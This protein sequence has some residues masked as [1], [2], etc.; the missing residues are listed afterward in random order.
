MI[1]LHDWIATLSMWWWPK[2]ADHL[3]QATLFGLVVL[4]AS[5]LL[6]R[7]PA[8]LRHSLWLLASIKF[9]IPAVA[10]VLLSRW[11]GLDSFWLWLTKP[12]T[13]TNGLWQ[14]IAAPAA[15]LLTNNYEL[16]VTATNGTHSEFYCALTG[17]WLAGCAVLIGIWWR[18]RTSYRSAMGDGEP[19]FSGREWLALERARKLLGLHRNV[20]LVLSTRPVEPGV[21][22]IWNPVIVL[23]E[24]IAKHLDDDELL[25]IMLHELVHIERRDNLIG[26]L[27]IALAGL[28]WFHPL[29]WFI[30]RKLFDERE[31]ACDER[32]LELYA[33]PETYAASILKVVRF[34]F[35]WN[36]AGVIG[37]GG[38]S[39]LRRRIE[40]IM[41]TGKGKRSVSIGAKILASIALGIALVAIV[42]G[43]TQSR[44]R[45]GQDA[46]DKPQP[47][48]VINPS[49]PEDVAPDPPS[50]VPQNPNSPAPP[51]SPSLPADLAQP[52]APPQRAD[53]AQPAAVVQPANPS[54][55]PTPRGADVIG[56]PAQPKNAAQPASPV[57][58]ATP[59]AEP[60]DVQ[61]PPQKPRA[62][63]DVKKG[64]L[65]SA[66]KPVYPAEAKEKKVEG[67]VAVEIVIGEEGTVVSA[68]PISGPDLLLGAA[69]DAAMQAR[70]EP[71]LV[72]GK[73]A[74]VTGTMSYK[75]ALKDK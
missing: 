1:A 35:G 66:P 75:F 22:K 47:Q 43:E 36:A 45:S 3:W 72:N 58:P 51:A 46:V 2:L 12:F 55:P 4:F 61:E 37:A 69:K 10:L 20:R 13:E 31:Q 52:P 56:V 15:V 30:S 9:V 27:Q 57:V 41:A 11:L 70:F 38:G 29:V 60:A 49:P 54:Q 24:S 64:K 59:P 8:G 19:T 25:V 7:G 63:K 40:N 44:K 17:I 26:K 16:T 18:N 14:G 39:N 21:C 68:R 23:P 34:S 28:F 71:T 53:I 65:I 74:K 33:V 48:N 42:V 62:E 32:V 50:E 67:Q 6:R 5:F 73:P